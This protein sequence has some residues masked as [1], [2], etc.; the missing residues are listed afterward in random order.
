M[1]GEM[2]ELGELG[3]LILIA[4]G[5]GPAHGY[6][7]GKEVK[8]RSGGRLDA[9]TGA[10]YQALRRLRDAQLVQPSDGPERAVDARRKYFELTAAGRRAVG[11][12][13]RRLEALVSAARER[14]LY[15]AKV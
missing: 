14:K 7:I 13:A 10:L 9:T 8:A 12:E 4:L 15:P 1:N 2:R 5:G 11:A 6:A 3:F